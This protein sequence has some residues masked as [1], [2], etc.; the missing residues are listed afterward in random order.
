[1]TLPLPNLDDRSYANLLEEAISQIPLE[2]PEW[3]DH[4]PT[5]TGIILIELLAWLTEMVLYRVNQIPDDNYASFLSLLKGEEW[6]LP[7]NISSQERQ[8]ILQSEI[9][10]TLLEVRKIYRAVTPADFEKLV[11][12]DWNKSE[13]ADNLKIA[14]VKCL[15]QRNLESTSDNF[16]KG[17]ISLV[18]VP[19]N[20]EINQ[21]N[22][23]ELLFKFLD[24]RRLL[25]TRLHILE[26]EYV[27]IA[28]E[29]ELVLRDGAQAEEVKKQAEKEVKIFFA[30]LRSGKYWQGK[31][32]PFGRSVYLS[33]L[34]KLLD[35]LEGVDYIENLQIKDNNNNSKSEINLADNQLVK[36]N[37]QD[38][39]FTI[40][41]EVGNERKKI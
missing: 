38:S 7:I 11:L 18:V 26:P 34:Y 16:A 15:A 9:Q 40:L 29:A 24:D 30:P 33:E 41:V 6:N 36:I 10:K 37:I 17:H 20:N 35:E 23:Y 2:Y 4:N 12:I 1:M 8:N 31:G 32:W 3:T 13:D 19:E 14:R 39:K 21:V 28:I 22:K 25:T 27:S 5:D